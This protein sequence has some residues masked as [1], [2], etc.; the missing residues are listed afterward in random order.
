MVDNKVICDFCENETEDGKFYYTYAV[1]VDTDKRVLYKGLNR[2]LEELADYLMGKNYH[3][4]A[5]QC[6]LFRPDVVNAYL[7]TTLATDEK[8]QVFYFKKYAICVECFAELANI[9]PLM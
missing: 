6:L 8:I 4:S 9:M 7:Q 3:L 5:S 2:V 1:L